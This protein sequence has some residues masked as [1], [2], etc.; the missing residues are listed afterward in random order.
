MQSAL[1]HESRQVA[2]NNVRHRWN[3]GE[4]DDDRSNESEGLGEGQWP[5]QPSSLSGHGKDRKKADH[6]CSD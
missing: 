5:K 3:D 4:R 1:T 6:G 2:E